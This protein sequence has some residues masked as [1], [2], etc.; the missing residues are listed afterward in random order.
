ML[1]ECN[2]SHL[3]NCKALIGSNQLVTYIPNCEDI[4]NDDDTDE[5]YFIA[6]I[7]MEN[8]LKEEEINLVLLLNAHVHLCLV[9]CY[10]CLH[11]FEYNKFKNTYIYKN[12]ATN[13]YTEVKSA[14]TSSP[15]D[16]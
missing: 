10:G 8:L 9:C 12:I 2:Q 13:K 1:K 7:M 5:Q 6:R 16:F 3:L 11:S 4:F 14:S 15:E